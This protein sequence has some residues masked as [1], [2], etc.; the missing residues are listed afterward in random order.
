MVNACYD[1][2]K[3]DI[4]F[5]A[6]I[7]KKPFYDVNQS[8]EENLGGIGSVIAH[9]ISHAFDNNGAHFDENGCLKDWWKEEDF[10]KFDELTKGMV[11]QFDGIVYHGVKVNGKLVV[12]ENI[13]DNGGL[14]VVLQ[15]MSKLDN[16]DYKA[17]FINYARIWCQKAQESY[18]KMLLTSDEHSPSELRAN[19]T[20][21]NFKE[22]Y[23]TF[24]VKETDKMYIPEDKRIVIW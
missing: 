15:I 13:A 9:E 1:P 6:A 18:I 24:D 23:N 8:L 3:N 4:T 7:L 17:F 16:P 14:A 22:W 12:S 20:P 19:I 2:F 5:P 11:E 10:K 21:R